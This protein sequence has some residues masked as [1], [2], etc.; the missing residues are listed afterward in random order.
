[1]QG[2][3]C[4]RATARERSSHPSRNKVG[5]VS[6][7]WPEGPKI[8]CTR[9][10]KI[11][12]TGRLQ[13]FHQG[14]RY[15]RWVLHPDCTCSFLYVLLVIDLLQGELEHRRVK[16]YYQRTNKNKTFVQQIG[17]QERR[18][19]ILRR[20][21]ERVASSSNHSKSKRARRRRRRRRVRKANEEDDTLPRAL[22]TL[23]YQMSHETR[24]AIRLSD[25]LQ[26]H[27]ND[28]AATVCISCC[29]FCLDS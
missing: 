2:I 18:D 24:H 5:L 27:E 9:D 11:S 17:R 7:W 20:I 15:L 6:L 1:V 28:I 21:S 25:W 26:Q 3:Q 22:P 13:S 29:L 19:A 23:R 14:F 12:F 16:K 8:Q 10:S 4:A